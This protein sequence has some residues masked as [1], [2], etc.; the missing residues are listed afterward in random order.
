MTVPLV[1]GN[2]AAVASIVEV[3]TVWVKLIALAFFSASLIYLSV[4][5]RPPRGRQCHW[6]GRPADSVPFPHDTRRHQFAE[7]LPSDVTWEDAANVLSPRQIAKHATIY[8]SDRGFSGEENGAN[9]LPESLAF[10][11]LKSRVDGLPRAELS[12]HLAP[13]RANCHDPQHPFDDLTMVGGRTSGRRSLRRQQ[14]N[15]PFP[16]H[17]CQRR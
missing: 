13:G 12:G 11:A 14:T 1:L 17:R 5:V 6:E 8:E 16:V 9:L 10:P 4:L 3:S 15:D 7:L 2:G